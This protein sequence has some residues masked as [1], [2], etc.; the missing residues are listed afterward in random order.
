[1]TAKSNQEIGGL[2]LNH[3]LFHH[4]PTRTL[5]EVQKVNDVQQAK[6]DVQE[7]YET[8]SVSK[9]LAA[10][11][12]VFADEGHAERFLYLHATF[13]SGKT[14]LLKLIGYATGQSNAPEPAEI[15]RQL[16]EGARAG[17]FGDHISDRVGSD[18]DCGHLDWKRHRLHESGHCKRLLPSRSW[19]KGMAAKRAR[20]G[21]RSA[22]VIRSA[23]RPASTPRPSKNTGTARSCR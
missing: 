8:D 23:T 22:T 16:G 4:D 14:H 19:G 5:E 10:L 11:G 13:G 20:V 9:V 15:A 3:Q 6:N 2:K 1:M 17:E 12:D 7:F 21:T 18:V